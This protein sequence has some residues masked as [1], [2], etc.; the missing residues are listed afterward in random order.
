[1]SIPNAKPFPQ[2]MCARFGVDLYVYVCVSLS[3][4]DGEIWERGGIQGILGELV[5]G[6]LKK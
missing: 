5:A 2:V 6:K 1:M 3:Q 4:T